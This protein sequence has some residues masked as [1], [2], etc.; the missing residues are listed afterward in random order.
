MT[1]RIHKK[2]D[3]FPREWVTVFR[4]QKYGRDKAKLL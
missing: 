3:L 1:I 2:C 4:G